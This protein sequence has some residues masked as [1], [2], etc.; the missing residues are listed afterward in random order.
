M[1]K[2]ITTCSLFSFLIFTSCNIQPQKIEYG[3][4][5][6]HFCRMNIVDQLHAAQLVTAKGKA[7]KYDAAE[8]MINDLEEIEP[9][10][11]GLLLVSD[12]NKPGELIDAKTATYIISKNIPSPMGAFLSSVSTKEEAL[13]LQKNKE[14][15][16]YS[17]D[18]LI[19]HLRK[20]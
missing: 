8:C 14:G 18:E 11:I 20:E 1:K 16:I 13:E 7:Y 17:W 15:E 12:Y 4:D 2:L 6:C 9:D 3:K 10:Q 5:A 19:N